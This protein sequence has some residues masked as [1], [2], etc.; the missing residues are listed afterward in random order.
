MLAF[1]F[2][3]QLYYRFID[4][5]DVLHVVPVN[6]SY[7]PDDSALNSLYLTM[8]S[9]SSEEFTF[10]PCRVHCTSEVKSSLMCRSTSQSSQTRCTETFTDIA[11]GL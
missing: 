10:C 2:V 7:L 6:Y 8:E 5:N 4:F 11:G 9:L 1:L 3:F